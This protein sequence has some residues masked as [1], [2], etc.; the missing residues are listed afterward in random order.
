L[1]EYIKLPPHI[2]GVA[3]LSAIIITI[4]VK[5]SLREDETIPKNFF[6]L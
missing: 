5:I 6:N 3:A 1:T 4:A 2:G